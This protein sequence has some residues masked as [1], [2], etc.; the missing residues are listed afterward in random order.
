MSAHSQILILAHILKSMSLPSKKTEFLKAL[1]IQ[2]P[3]LLHSSSPNIPKSTSG[4]QDNFSMVL[5]SFE[6]LPSYK[7][8]SDK[9][10]DFSCSFSVAENEQF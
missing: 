1:N 7:A 9:S 2:S 5:G 4:F 6:V 3:L 10:V 8:F